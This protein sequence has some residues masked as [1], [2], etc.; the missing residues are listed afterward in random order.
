MEEREMK[1]YLISILGCAAILA[2]CAK[3]NIQEVNNP[4]AGGKQFSATIER[5]KTV[6]S[7]ED[8]VFWEAADEISIGGVIFVAEVDASD[9]SKA[10][11][12]KKNES[13][14]DPEKVDGKYI[15]CYPASLGEC[16]LPS[17]QTYKEGKGLSGINPMYAE[18]ADY[19]LSFSN[20][21]ALLEI[22]LTG[23]GNVTS[24]KVSDA[25]KGLS[26]AFT[27]VDNT[28]VLTSE[29]LAAAV[30]VALDCG[31]GVALSEDAKPFYVAVPAGEY[32][33]LTI[34]A[35]NDEGKEFVTKLKSGVKAVI[36]RNTI[37]PITLAAVFG[38][39]G[40]LSGVFTVASGR[41]IQF[42][43]GNL[44]YSNNTWQVENNQYA[45]GEGWDAGH[46]SLFAWTDAGD[47]GYGADAAYVATDATKVDWGKIYCQSNGIASGTWRTLTSAEWKYLLD[48]RV[49]KN[50]FV[51]YTS[52]ME[53][54]VEIEGND[55]CGLFIYPDDYAGTVVDGT[56]T[57]KS[58]AEKGI[59]FLPAAG[60]RNGTATASQGL[61]GYYWAGDSINAAIADNIR[62]SSNGV[63]SYN[64]F[65][66]YMGYA[67]RLV[68][69]A[70]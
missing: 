13:D 62:F 17:S 49:M 32:E 59:V 52:T 56:F 43:V 16:V 8:K 58:I 48:T 21:C 5:T 4:V 14:P 3:D 51:R 65:G 25:A 1:K 70:E 11:F 47:K 20:V 46:V 23:T 64:A 31:A 37:Y 2:G 7:D 55:Y 61:A 12:T 10:V 18:S 26:G 53:N 9:P 44:Y 22:N 15:A 67:V 42:S 40:P 30:G 63:S 60:S 50:N 66:R 41:K 45:Y 39:P 54:P 69:A 36:E 29:A 24:V 33:A 68:T 34:R 38:E 28:A 27:V 35:Y 19:S 6:L 57:W